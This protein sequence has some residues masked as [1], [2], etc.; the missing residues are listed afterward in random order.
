METITFYSYKGGTGRTLVVANVA[1]Y[2]R[3]L[4]VPSPLRPIGIRETIQGSTPKH[5]IRA[6]AAFCNTFRI[7]LQK[8][9]YRRGRIS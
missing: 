3:C 1:R 5:G 7:G 6:T 8:A 2:A 9:G 4:S